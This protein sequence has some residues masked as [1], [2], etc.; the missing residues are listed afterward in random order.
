MNEMLLRAQTENP[1]SLIEWGATRW[2]T[3]VDA[4]KR[5]HQV[6][7][8]INYVVDGTV[9]KTYRLNDEELRSMEKA[10]LF[11]TPFLCHNCQFPAG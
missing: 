2:N 8:A 5:F 3:K 11:L 1:F 10:I 4:M 9:Q 6:N 7:V